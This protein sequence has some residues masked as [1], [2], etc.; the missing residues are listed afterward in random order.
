MFK[1]FLSLFIALSAFWCFSEI[2]VGPAINNLNNRVVVLEDKATVDGILAMGFLTNETDRTAL[3]LIGDT[4]LLNQAGTNLVLSINL[5]DDKASYPV[6]IYGGIK[7]TE[8]TNTWIE[9]SGSNIM[10]YSQGECFG[11]V[12]TT[13]DLSVFLTL[14]QND[15]IT[16][17]VETV[18][19][20]LSVYSNAVY[21][22]DTGLTGI[23]FPAPESRAN[24]ENR[25]TVHLFKNTGDVNWFPNVTWI[26]EEAPQFEVSNT[27]YVFQFESLD[28]VN[29]R[30]W[31]EYI[32]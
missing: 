12:M 5:V 27:N 20:Y 24:K 13:N 6:K 4:N 18:S 16:K 22:L 23:T 21:K 15:Y 9:L 3:S 1:K 19:Q 14:I 30:G 28:G 10:I 31:L 17:S 25:L 11:R 8:G 26:Y 7:N 2:N 29:W 32:Y